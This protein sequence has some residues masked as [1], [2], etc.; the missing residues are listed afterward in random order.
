MADILATQLTAD[1]SK[2]I[3]GLEKARKSF[4]KFSSNSVKQIGRTTKAFAGLSA[5]ALLFGG[6]ATTV[7]VK[8]ASDLEAS[9]T[10]VRK[11]TGLSET[12]LEK[13]RQS[14]LK[15]STAV[16][17]SANELAKIGEVAGQ[18]GVK[19]VSNIR[20]FTETIAK[21]VTVTDFTVQ[22]AAASLAKLSNLF[23]I[24]IKE[25]G[26]LASAMNE[27]EN[28]TTA[29]SPALVEFMR[30]IA[31]SA[32][33]L[34][35]TASEVA[36]LSATL[37]GLGYQ[38]ESAGTAIQKTFLAMIT[39]G[40]VFADQ[41][42]I[43]IG[44]FQEMVEKDAMGTL[45][46]WLRLLAETTTPVE[47]IEKLDEIGLRGERVRAVLLGLKDA[48]ADLATNVETSNKAFEEATSLQKEFEV[49]MGA[50]KNQ[51]K[52]LF[53]AIKKVAIELGTPLLGPFKQLMG[54]MKDDL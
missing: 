6:T 24:P 50:T 38:A 54:I 22:E 39:Q 25:V 17:Q 4:V 51:F 48:T 21:V 53:D 11:T 15:L 12:E 26:R 23:A 30:R 10:D 16:P 29:T 19:G 5:K 28:S 34:K 2:L 46:E 35:I 9:M 47:F 3:K 20:S 32:T 18:L 13:L 37:I 41:M 1:P 14:F 33:Q 43:S 8:M 31:P 52:T 45:Q 27:L 42:G 7:F 40:K 49:F 44:K 36:G